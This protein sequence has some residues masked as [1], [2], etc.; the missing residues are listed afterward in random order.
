MYV[1]VFQLRFLQGI[2]GLKTK[3]IMKKLFAL[4]HLVSI[5]FIERVIPRLGRAAPSHFVVGGQI[6]QKEKNL[7]GWPTRVLSMPNLPQEV[8]FLRRAIKPTRPSPASNMA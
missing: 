6:F 5:S 8:C 2:E 1:H 7:E 4:T 3:E